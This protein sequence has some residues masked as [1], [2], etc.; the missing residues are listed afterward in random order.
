MESGFSLLQNHLDIQL[1]FGGHG[2]RIGM[3]TLAGEL[4]DISYHDMKE[5]FPTSLHKCWNQ[6]TLC[7]TSIDYAT[8]DGYLSYELYSRVQ[9]MKDSLGPSWLDKLLPLRKKSKGTLVNL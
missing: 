1:K 3:A 9:T 8:V 2:D 4:I 7:Q 6:K 5:N